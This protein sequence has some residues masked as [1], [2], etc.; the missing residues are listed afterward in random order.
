MDRDDARCVPERL[1]LRVLQLLTTEFPILLGHFRLTPPSRYATSRTS[2]DEKIFAAP[3]LCLQWPLVRTAGERMGIAPGL[4]GALRSTVSSIPRT[5]L[6]PRRTGPP[7]S[8][9]A[10]VL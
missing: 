10:F 3:F 2:L 7:S 1:T 6:R 4:T 5:A 8:G 9:A